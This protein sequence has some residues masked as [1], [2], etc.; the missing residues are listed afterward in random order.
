MLGKVDCIRIRVSDIEA[1]LR[2]YRD[3]LGLELVWKRG[4]EEAALKLKE[5]DTEVVLVS[6]DLDA[7]E[8]DFLVDRSEV[9]AQKFASLGGK[10]KVQPFDIEIGRCSV[11]SDPWGNRFVV[12]DMTKG[13]LKTDKNGNIEPN[14]AMTP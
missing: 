2:F 11:V 3:G 4:A 8:V 14:P 7:E 6:K 10:V 12:L 1:G 9:A 13:R 5:S